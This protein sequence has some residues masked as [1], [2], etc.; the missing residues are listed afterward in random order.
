MPRPPPLH[1]RLHGAARVHQPVLR[2]EPDLRTLPLSSFANL[3]EPDPTF[4][5]M[6]LRLACLAALALMASASGYGET[7]AVEIL[8]A[9]PGESGSNR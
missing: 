4:S 9:K 7:V 2:S 1:R 6:S 5:S 3:L 8:S